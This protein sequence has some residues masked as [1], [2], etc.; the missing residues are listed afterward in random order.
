M[1]LPVKLYPEVL[2]LLV[3]LRKALHK[4]PEP[5]GAEVKTR[6]LLRQFFER[7]A[8]R[9]KCREYGQ[10]SLG[11][12]LEGTG[13]GKTLVLRAELDAVPFSAGAH[14]D[15]HA[16]H[17]CGH[18]GHMAM[19]AGLALSMS[20][21]G[22]ARGR[23][24]LLFQAAEENGLGAKAVSSDPRFPVLRP[25]Y[26]LALHNFPQRPLGQVV[27]RTGTMCCASRGLEI[28]LRGKPGHAAHPETGCSP[29]LTIG[30]LI[31]GLDRINKRHLSDPGI[32]M[33]T[34]IGAR[35]GDKHFGSTPDRAVLWA[36]LRTD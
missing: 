26:I 15:A 1:V 32:R 21:Q 2:N 34:V 22:L 24:L 19:L 29:A 35:L 3:D 12:I 17:R 23:I 25:D 36:T 28:E 30:R 10:G 6:A 33:V 20:R 9:W 13:A 14:G 18:D 7:H 4:T 8:P 27:L 11:W 16:S 31:D 5:A